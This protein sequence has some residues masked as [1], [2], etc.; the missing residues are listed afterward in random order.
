MWVLL[1]EGV[2]LDLCFVLP[3]MSSLGAKK[4]QGFCLASSFREGCIEIT[5]S[6]AC[7]SVR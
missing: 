1:T 6:G 5:G 4:I 7:P 3:L 2:R